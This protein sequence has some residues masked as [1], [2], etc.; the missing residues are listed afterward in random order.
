MSEISGKQREVVLLQNVIADY[1]VG[2]LDILRAKSSHKISI[3][4]GEDDFSVATKTF[5][6]VW[7]WACPVRN[8]FLLGRR[9]LWQ[10]GEFGK[11]IHCDLLILNFNLRILNHYPVLLLRWL[12]RK[13]TLLWGH[14]EGRTALTKYLGITQL[15]FA[16]AFICYT[17]AQA[18]VFRKRYPFIKTFV[19]SNSCLAME[20]CRSAQTAD[21]CA[22]DIVYVGRMVKDKKPDLLLRSFLRAKAERKLPDEARLVFVGSGPMWASLQETAKQSEYAGT[23]VFTGH[24]SALD[25][26]RE[27]YKTAFCCVNPGYVGLTVIQSFAFGVPVLVADREPHSPEIEACH[28]LEFGSFFQADS[29]EG[30]VDKLEETWEKRH[31]YGQRSEK[32]VEYIRN[33]YTFETMAD[34]FI[35]AMDY[36]VGS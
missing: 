12:R 1:R 28:K 6:S 23:V 18:Q 22:V 15:I 34:G 3:L 31:E 24:I 14:V 13:P 11:L 17:E 32:V 16:R 26:L 10:S 7:A 4:C 33:H 29:V 36:A 5:P 21:D 2:F 19:A 9:F 35:K 27:V 30:L 25:R 8:R 20:D